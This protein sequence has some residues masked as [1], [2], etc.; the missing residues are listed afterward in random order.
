[1]GLR[2]ILYEHSFF[3]TWKL[4]LSF[5]DTQLLQSYMVAH[6]FLQGHSFCHRCIFRLS[7][8]DT[9]Q[10]MHGNSFYH[11]WTIIQILRGH[12]SNPTW[13]PILIY[14]YTRSIP[15]GRS[16]HIPKLIRSMIHGHSSY[17]PWTRV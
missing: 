10:I 7:F 14:T 6:S 9:Y 13:T 5:V 17:P 11:T 1:M 3:P 4:V 8:M 16:Y 15:H 2:Y 12:L